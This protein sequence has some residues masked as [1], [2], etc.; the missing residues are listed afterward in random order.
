MQ[1]EKLFIGGYI[2]EDMLCDSTAGVDAILAWFE[3]LFCKQAEELG[4][5]ALLPPKVYFER[6]DPL[7]DRA[8][9]IHMLESKMLKVKV[10]GRAAKVTKLSQLFSQGAINLC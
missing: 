8:L 6:I 1:T 3:H 5:V 4:H 10:V 7:S 2:S 9:D